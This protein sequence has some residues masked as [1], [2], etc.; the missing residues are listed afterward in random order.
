[1]NDKNN[2][3]HEA[4]KKSG[5]T[6]EGFRQTLI[7]EHEGWL[8]QEAEYQAWLESYNSEMDESVNREMDMV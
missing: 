1:M 8:R 4:L 3:A 6:D 2:N 5:Y 7:D